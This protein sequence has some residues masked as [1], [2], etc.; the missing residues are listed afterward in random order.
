MLGA[1][2]RDPCLGAAR[3]P[4][5]ESYSQVLLRA[6]G[7][8]HEGIEQT[9]LDMVLFPNSRSLEANALFGPG[10][11]LI[12]RAIEDRAVA[13]IANIL[14]ELDDRLSHRPLELSPSDHFPG[15]QSQMTD[16]D[17]EENWL[18]RNPV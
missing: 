11:S 13:E 14:H 8:T 6:V 1:V 7:P 12:S 5:P 9:F 16:G 3:R 10:R 18:G 2:R 17:S 15:L 4:L